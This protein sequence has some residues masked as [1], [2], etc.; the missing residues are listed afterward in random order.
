MTDCDF[1]SC[2]L[3]RISSSTLTNRVASGLNN[4]TEGKFG[5][6]ED[7]GRQ[8]YDFTAAT[9][10]PVATITGGGN[11]SSFLVTVEFTSRDGG[12]DCY[13]TNTYSVRSENGVPVVTLIGTAAVAR[14]VVTTA[15]SGTTGITISLNCTATCSGNVVVRA[16]AGGASNTT[17]LRGVTVTMA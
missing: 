10:K 12:G 7:S 17:N 16:R 6:L 14:V 8:S 3:G 9:A 13:A 1:V 4:Y 5:R 2:T 15:A 11:F